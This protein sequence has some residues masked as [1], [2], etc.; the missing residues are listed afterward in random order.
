VPKEVSSGVPTPVLSGRDLGDEQ[1]PFSE[2]LWIAGDWKMNIK[3]ESEST[4]SVSLGTTPELA[5]DA[6]AIRDCEVD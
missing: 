1:A 6:E 3:T 2:T 5:A 4:P